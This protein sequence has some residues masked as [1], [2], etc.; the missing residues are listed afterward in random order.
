M[1]DYVCSEYGIM[2]DYKTAEMF[3]MNLQ[4]FA[5]VTMQGVHV[6]KPCTYEMEVTLSQVELGKM[7]M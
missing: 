7:T 5:I 6:Y 2:F 1:F 3:K 4:W